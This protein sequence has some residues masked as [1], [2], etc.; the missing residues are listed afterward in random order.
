M[1]GDAHE[2]AQ[3][4]PAAAHRPIRIVHPISHRQATPVQTWTF[5]THFVAIGIFVIAIAIA[6]VMQATSLVAIGGLVTTCLIL[7][8]VY[9]VVRDANAVHRELES[10]KA[11][12]FRVCPT[13]C[14]D[15]EG[16]D[17]EGPCPECGDLYDP[18]YLELT[19]TVAYWDFD[20]RTPKKSKTDYLRELNASRAFATRATPSGVRP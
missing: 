1:N 15:L 6:G 17:S 2:E 5:T 11:R 3:A 8:L 14:Y 16:C 20:E 13:C 12:G 19:W 7:P 10:L 4:L 9:R 18:K